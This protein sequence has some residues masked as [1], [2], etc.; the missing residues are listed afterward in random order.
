MKRLTNLA[1]GAAIVVAV[2]ALSS[3]TLTA[4]DQPTRLVFVDAQAAISAHP[5]GQAA[6]L[7]QEQ[8]RQ[9]LGELRDDIDVLTQRLRAGEQLTPEEDELYRTLL[10]TL[11]TVQS[12][13]QADVVATATPA[14][15][16]VNQTIGAVAEENGYTV[17]LDVNVA[18]RDGLVVYAQDG[19][20]IT[21]T[22]VERIRADTGE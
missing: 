14:I 1:I 8:A 5:A 6:D 15:E 20:D 17:V 10:T 3:V 12:R 21:A 16:A 19:L 13:Y 7:L 22:V 11:E 4:Q 9:E 2:L 18:A